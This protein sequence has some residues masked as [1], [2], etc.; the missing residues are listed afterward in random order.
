M[1]FLQQKNE[2]KWTETETIS[3]LGET[4]LSFLGQLGWKKQNTSRFQML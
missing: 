3:Q 2:R 4:T 1:T